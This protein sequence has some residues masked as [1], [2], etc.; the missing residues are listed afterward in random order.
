MNKERFKYRNTVMLL[1]GCPDGRT[2]GPHIS[3]PLPLRL[4]RTTSVHVACSLGALCA[5]TP[6][7]TPPLA[8]SPPL[9]LRGPARA[10]AR[11]PVVCPCP[12]SHLP[13]RSCSIR[14][15]LPLPRSVP[16]MSSTPATYGP[17]HGIELYVDEPLF[18]QATSRCYAKSAC[19][20]SMFQVF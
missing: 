9:V 18:V 19:C 20:N 8:A 1:I 15:T 6:G 14:L 4:A 12:D 13:S 16:P 2:D 3:R 5:S 10:P 11:P 17:L 7:R